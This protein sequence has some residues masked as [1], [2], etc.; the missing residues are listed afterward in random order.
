MSA[1]STTVPA[2]VWQRHR[3]TVR[4]VVVVIALVAL[5]GWATGRQSATPLDPDNASANGA[6]AVA[7]VLG[8]EGVDVDVVRSADQLEDTDVAGALVV[9]TSAD[10]LG[11]A[12]T[13]RL[14]DHVPADGLV[15]VDPPE[16]VARV[17]GGPVGGAVPLPDPLPA[18]CNDPRFA[19]LELDV[20][21][22]FHFPS[23]Q[24][25]FGNPAGHVLAV[26]SRGLTLFG[27]GQALSNEQ[28]VEGD[29]AAVALRLLGQRDR[30]VWY[31]PTVADLS[32][33]DGVGIRQFLPPWTNQ[34]LALLVVA[35]LAVMWWRGR[36]LGPLVVE[37]LP[38]VV[39]SL[40]TTE[41]RGRLYRR[42]GDRGHAADAL[43]AGTRA[44]LARALALPRTD[45]AGLV[46]G[47]VG[48]AARAAGRRTDDVRGLLAPDAPPPASDH[49]LITLADAL[50]DLESEVSR[51]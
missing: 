50:A 17:L 29:N 20:P 7:R 19:D 1:P 2:G 40:E 37:P 24:G 25:C 34:A 46:D 10:Q 39:R 33:G 11:R 43:R 14:L 47:L 27:A 15:V 42:A 32:A 4:I 18:D 35:L 8:D 28:V 51:S 44:R 9:V 41:S 16:E 21:W 5:V 38:V 12:T 6:R 45:D 23:P 26:D 13:R 3:G 49:D 30:L 22:A 31:V 36:R 48:A